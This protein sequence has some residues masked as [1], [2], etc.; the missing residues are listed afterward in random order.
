M[1]SAM[2]SCGSA[3][4][5]QKNQRVDTNHRQLQV[6][7]VGLSARARDGWRRGQHE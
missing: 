3:H 4:E 7:S 6:E 2:K 1:S 5:T